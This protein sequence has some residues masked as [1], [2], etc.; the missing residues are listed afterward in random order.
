VVEEFVP[1]GLKGVKITLD[2]FGR[3]HDAKR[4]FADGRGSFDRI[5]KN[6]YDAAGRIDVDV[7]G[8]FDRENIDSFPQMLDHLEGLGLTEKLHRVRFKPIS[9]TPQDRAGMADSDEMACVFG[10]LTTAEHLVELRRLAMDRGFAVDPGVGVNACSMTA[11]NAVFTIDPTGK[12]FKCPA[13]VGHDAFAVGSID[14]GEAGDASRAE[15][16]GRSETGQPWRRCSGC[17]YVPLCGDGCQFGSYLRYGDPSRLNCRKEFVEHMVRE[18]L[19]LNY[20]Q[21]Q[22][23]SG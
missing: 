4:P 22:N 15:A 6:V 2:G 17:V 14:S 5:V 8:N 12:I 18:N 20:T 11:N 13:F 1:L 9:E 16:A 23:K 21:R 3:F 19:K 10:D 7:G